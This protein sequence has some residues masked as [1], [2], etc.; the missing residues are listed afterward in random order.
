MRAADQH[1]KAELLGQSDLFGL[2]ATE[3]DEVE[4]AFLKPHHLQIISGL[5]V[6]KIP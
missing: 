3:P 4:Q 1:N 6:K 2:L 5:M